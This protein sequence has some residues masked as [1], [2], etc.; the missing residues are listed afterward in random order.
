MSHPLR[1]SLRHQL[2]P[3]PCDDGCAPKRHVP[4]SGPKTGRLHPTPKQWENTRTHAHT[5]S[6]TFA[7]VDI[8]GA[9]GVF[10]PN[11]SN[12]SLNR[13]R[14]GCFHICFLEGPLQ[15]I[16]MYRTAMINNI[17]RHP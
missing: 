4:H 13:Q 8:M 5:P 17:D 6:D 15:P 14:V 16:R 2:R 11:D 7:K 12:R 3:H 9:S 1:R 10:R